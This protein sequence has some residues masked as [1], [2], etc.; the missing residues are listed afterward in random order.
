MYKT[1]SDAIRIRHSSRLRASRALV[2]IATLLAS[3]AGFAS[4]AQG[5]DKLI[6]WSH[7]DAEVAGFKIYTRSG[8]DSFSLSI[9]F[10]RAEIDEENGIFRALLTRLPTGR[11]YVVVTAY[12]EENE[13]KQE[14]IYS[15]EGIIDIAAPPVI[16]VDTDG[17][18]YPDDED[19]FPDDVTEWSDL[20]GDGYGDT[21]SDAFINDASEWLDS[22]GDG[23]GNNSDAYPDDPSRS[24]PEPEP[25]PTSSPYRV[26]FGAGKDYYDDT[27]KVWTRDAGFVSDGDANKTSS[28]YEIA[29]SDGRGLLYRSSRTGEAGAV[30]MVFSVPLTN[31]RYIVHL[32]FSEENVNAAGK[33][34]FDVEIE[35]ERVLH[36]FD[37]YAETGGRHRAVVKTF[38]TE[39]DDGFLEV[40][41]RYSHGEAGP[42]VMAME[43]L[44]LDTDGVEVLTSPGKPYRLDAD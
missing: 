24:E 41:F 34:G 39:V 17:D 7:S 33:R 5:E 31:G 42:I 36:G 16:V 19:A 27:D 18:G 37:I 28:D 4:V 8:D 22:D 25:D 14:S 13:Q 30:P 9:D 10:T 20:D 29:D 38:T 21:H 43:V 40:V 35:G 1:N 15:N 3:F 44:S 2:A 6:R 11:T 32:H 26:N 12:Y 23:V